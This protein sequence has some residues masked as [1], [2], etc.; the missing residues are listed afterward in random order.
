[1]KAP[2]TSASSQAPRLGLL[3]TDTQRDGAQVQQAL[4]P[5]DD[6]PETVTDKAH[7][8]GEERGAQDVGKRLK[9][10][11]AAAERRV[12]ELT[13]EA[14][15]ARFDSEDAQAR[16]LEAQTK[17]YARFVLFSTP[18]GLPGSVDVLC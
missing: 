7:V 4:N 10:A 12:S 14:A 11:M 17:V 1:M 9:E 16:H 15:E 5:V 3:Q 13:R 2:H 8:K 18:K 6:Q